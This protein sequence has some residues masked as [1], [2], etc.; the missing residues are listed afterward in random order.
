[1][2]LFQIF[3]LSLLLLILILPL[4]GCWSSIEIEEMGLI[5][6]TALDLEKE[7]IDEDQE[8]R[9]PKRDMFTITNQLVT[10]ETTDSGTRDG[11]TQH[12]AYKN[13]SETGDA[14][15]P[16]LRKMILRIDKRAFG[17]H[18]KVIVI[19]EDLARNYNLKQVLD[20]FKREQEMRPSALIVI[21]KENARRTLETNE[22]TVIPA[23]QLV[24]MTQ[25]QKRTTEILLPMSITRFEGQLNSG[26]SFLLQ[27]VKPAKGERILSGAAIIDGKTKKLRGFL[28]DTETEGVTWITGEGKGG[29]VRSFDEDTG[30]PIIYE[31]LSM[32]SKIKPSIKGESI[33]FDVKIESEGRIGEHWDLSGEPFDNKFLKKAERM[34]EKEVEYLVKSALAKAQEEYQMDVFGFGNKLRIEHP[35]LWEKV[36]EDW[37][38][39]FSEVPVNIDVNIIIKEFGTTG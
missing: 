8:G 27:S 12:Q 38:K 31:I 23:I 18:A 22:P 14:I 33:S 6:G 35:K 15:L 5:I 9:Y 21:A 30:Q 11:T 29:L 1:M 36:K 10:A 17:E 19:G 4:S 25:G 32:E 34:T 26:T 28:D 16:A 3:L 24:E 13:I 20:F 7:G 2:K 39:T 37:D